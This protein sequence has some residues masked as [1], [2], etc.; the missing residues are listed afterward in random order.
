MPHLIH[1]YQDVELTPIWWSF[2]A[3][4]PIGEDC[5]AQHVA[6]WVYYDCISWT[7]IVSVCQRL[8]WLSR[9]KWCTIHKYLPLLSLLSVDIRTWLVSTC[10][11]LSVVKGQTKLQ[12]LRDW[13]NWLMGN[14]FLFREPVNPD[15][16]ETYS[17]DIVKK[18]PKPDFLM[19]RLT[20]PN[21]LFTDLDAPMR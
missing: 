1:S 4:L 16:S 15:I 5:I 11:K 17:D 14:I 10:V 21:G 6:I 18:L 2:Y 9:T 7:S 3:F 12:F 20:F 19:D 13:N 8:H